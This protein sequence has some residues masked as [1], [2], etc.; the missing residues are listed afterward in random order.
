MEDAKLSPD[1]SP[2]GEMPSEKKKKGLKKLAS[3]VGHCASQSAR[4]GRHGF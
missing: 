2:G 4:P 3:K 1:S